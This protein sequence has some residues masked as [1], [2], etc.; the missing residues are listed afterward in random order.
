MLCAAQN[1]TH[2]LLIL[3]EVFSGAMCF[4]Q[5]R[6]RS[7]RRELPGMTLGCGRAVED[8]WSWRS[9]YQ[10]LLATGSAE[11]SF[12]SFKS[13][14]GRVCECVCLFT[15]SKQELLSLLL[16]PVIRTGVCH[17]GGWGWT[18]PCRSSV[19]THLCVE[20]FYLTFSRSCAP[21]KWFPCLC[22]ENLL[23]LF[24]FISMWLIQGH[25]LR[26]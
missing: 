7:V 24:L 6:G 11:S 20:R 25:M 18:E 17:A 22:L 26:I 19:L 13:R 1:Y 15:R 21:L 5:D 12:F 23:C 10:L 3:K 9:W 2:W 4:L 16:S 8:T 14:V